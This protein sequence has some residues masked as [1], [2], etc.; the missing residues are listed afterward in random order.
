MMHKTIDTPDVQL[1]KLLIARKLKDE[2]IDMAP[3]KIVVTLKSEAGRNTKIRF[4]YPAA[5]VR[6][7]IQSVVGDSDELTF[8]DIVEMVEEQAYDYQR[9]LDYHDGAEELIAE[10]KVTARREI[11]KAKRRGLA[12]KL[13]DVQPS[14]VE[15]GSNELPSA[16]VTIEMLSAALVPKPYGVVAQYSEEIVRDLTE[17]RVVL[18]QTLRSVRKKWLDGVG[19]GGAIDA[20]ALAALRSS[21]QDVPAV[22]RRMRESDNGFVVWC[23]DLA[24]SLRWADGL[25]KANFGITKEISYA[26]SSLSLEGPEK[27]ASTHGLSGKPAGVVVESPLLE[28]AVIMTAADWGG[29]TIVTLEPRFHVFDAE[30]LEPRD[31]LFLL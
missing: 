20:V 18:N 26:N 13:L 15:A 3:E 6:V 21:G 27:L 4:R 22:I 11:A 29:T 12:W 14:T 5:K 28:G 31:Q 9:M 24:L 1:A 10:A 7:T 8:G 25:I 16:E 30:T 17:E 2:G 19:A 23:G